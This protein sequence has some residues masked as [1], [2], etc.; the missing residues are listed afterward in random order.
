[1]ADHEKDGLGGKNSFSYPIDDD[2]KGAE[3][4]NTP[5]Y[6]PNFKENV[7][8]LLK[9]FQ[10]PIFPRTI[11]TKFTNNT[12]ISVNNLDYLYSEFEKSGFIDCRISAF[13]S[14]DKP[15]PNLVFIDLDNN[16]NHKTPLAKILESTLTKIKK[17][18]GGHPTVL[19]TGNG[20]HIYQ[21]FEVLQSLT[22]MDEFK[23]FENVDNR[24]LQFEKDFLSDGHADKANHPSLKSC[25]LRV[26]GSLNSKCIAR[27]LS[28]EESKVKIIQSWDGK[29]VPIS[30]QLGTFH[31]HL[32]S[33]RQKKE[34]RRTI[35][36][37]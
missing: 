9:H 14:I 25:L 15:V 29:R 18:L 19:W 32:V 24:F 17:R 27:G 21:P 16:P 11:S 7:Q 13:P 2:L 33:Q 31:S 28:G 37:S 12:Q 34:K 30:Y 36:G 3:R 23:D 10:E 5:Y 26:P 4:K 8:F 22:E 35:Y 1:M 6:Y 20:Y